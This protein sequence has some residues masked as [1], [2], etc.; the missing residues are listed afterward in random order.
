[1]KSGAVKTLLIEIAQRHIG[2]WGKE[3]IV[4]QCKR[5]DMDIDAL[6]PEDMKT[7]AEEAS[8]TAVVIIGE[9][10]ANRLKADILKLS[11]KMKN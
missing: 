8:K 3:F 9:T 2:D 5:L 11:E 1:M 10:R 4:H 6:S 7:L